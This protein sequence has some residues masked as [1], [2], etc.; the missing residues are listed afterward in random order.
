MLIWYANLFKAHMY[1]FKLYEKTVDFFSILLLLT[2]Y[3][4]FCLHNQ[5][6]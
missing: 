6:E 1:S 3:I 2:S 5:V 4:F